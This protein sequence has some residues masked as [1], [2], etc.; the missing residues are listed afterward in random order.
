MEAMTKDKV[1][2]VL[3]LCETMDK[4]AT[5]SGHPAAVLELLG[6]PFSGMV[7]RLVSFMVQR[8]GKHAREA[9]RSRG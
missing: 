9:A 4:D 1:E 3:N 7:D 5:L 2:M 6:I 8:W